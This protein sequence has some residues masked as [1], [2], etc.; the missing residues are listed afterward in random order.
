MYLCMYIYVCMYVYTC[1]CIYICFM[2]RYIYNLHGISL[3]R[4]GGLDPARFSTALTEPP[5]R[6]QGRI[7]TFL[8]RERAHVNANVIT[9]PLK[10]KLL[11]YQI[12]NVALT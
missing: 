4:R 12:I 1:I 10:L 9:F 5:L 6:F 7:E 3:A 11:V 8:C 2:Y